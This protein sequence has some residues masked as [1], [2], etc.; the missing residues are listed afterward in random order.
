[1]QTTST[2]MVMMA[3]DLCRAMGIDVPSL[4]HTLQH[5]GFSMASPHLTS[6]NSSEMDMTIEYV[7]GPVDGDLS[8]CL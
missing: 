7:H 5:D 1:M 4:I 2:N 6:V 3:Q 8:S